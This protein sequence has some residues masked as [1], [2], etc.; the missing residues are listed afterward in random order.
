MYSAVDVVWVVYA[1]KAV[2]T[3]SEA[4]ALCRKQKIPH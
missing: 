4:H 1:V 3:E 2:D